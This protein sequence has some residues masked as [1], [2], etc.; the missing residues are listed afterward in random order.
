MSYLS[1][2]R[3]PTPMKITGRSSSITNAFINSIIPVLPPSEDDVKEAL[4]VLK[5]SKTDFQCVYCGDGATEWDHLRPLVKEQKPTGYI[6]EIQNL[7]PSCGKCN[8]SKGNK[9]WF[10]WILS[11]AP[12]SPKTREVENLNLRIENLQA[13]ESWRKPTKVNFEDIV[14]S[15]LWTQHWDNWS[16]V[17]Q[18]MT[19]SQKLANEIK[20]IV[21]CSQNTL[22][23]I[24]ISSKNE[25][26]SATENNSNNFCDKEIEKVRKKLERWS[27]KPNQI[28]C[29]ILNKYLELNGDQQPI[30]KNALQAAL[31]ELATFNSNF[32]QMKMISDKNHAKIFE[33]NN[34]IIEVWEPVRQLVAQYKREIGNG[35]N[36]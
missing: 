6:S 3:M 36:G 33:V 12:K 19:E 10:D 9:N 35:V 15:E 30:T 25:S 14:G 13:Y 11:D 34:E 7:V 31:P 1:L 16:Q 29:K 21:A 4:N 23:N 18:V 17:L 2:F 28:C 26:N 20:H 8:Q 32:A 27:K 5:I 24:N 22:S